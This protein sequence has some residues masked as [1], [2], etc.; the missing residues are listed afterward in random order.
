MKAH[1]VPLRA[2]PCHRDPD[3]SVN[4]VSAICVEARSAVFVC[5]FQN[6]GG[7]ADASR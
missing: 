6:T 2:R 7:C 5:S 4:I 1:V 3:V